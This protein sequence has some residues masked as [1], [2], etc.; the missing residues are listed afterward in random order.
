MPSYAGTLSAEDRWH[1]A[2][3][4]WALQNTDQYIENSG[5]D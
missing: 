1:L 4:V 2:N 3:Y 5:K